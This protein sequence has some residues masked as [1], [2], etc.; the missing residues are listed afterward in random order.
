MKIFIINFLFL[1]YLPANSQ[2]KLPD[3]FKIGNYVE[4]FN[5]D[6]IKIYFSC[7][8]VITDK[9]CASYY[10]IGKMDSTI[11]NV[12]GD[13][14]DYD[15]NNKISL[16]GTML[17]NDLEGVAHYYYNNGKIK[18]EGAYKNNIRQGKWIFYYRN[19]KIQHVYEYVNG[20]PTVLEAYSQNGKATVV[21]GNGSFITEFSIDRQCDKFT[22]SGE[23]LNGKKHGKWILSTPKSNYSIGTEN[24]EEGKFIKANI[25]NNDSTENPKIRFTNFYAHENLDLIDNSP[26][27]PGET[28]FLWEYDNKSLYSSFYPALQEELI[29]YNLPVENQWL[30]VGIK[31]NKKN[32]VTEINIASSIN[33][34]NLENFVHSSLSNMKKWKTAIVNKNKTESN[35]FFS[36]LVDNNQIII[37]ANYVFQNTED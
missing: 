36:I 33:D 24:Y 4:V 8:G 18:E 10:R 28:F 29:N 22:A 26:G 20:E 16:K 19:G 2:S 17:N 13:F 9:K 31:V 6:S 7:T 27:C 32:K 3:N 37:P 1:L 30:V 12:T 11:I 25:N 23:L 35:I 34:N 15:M 5:M 14:I 21:N